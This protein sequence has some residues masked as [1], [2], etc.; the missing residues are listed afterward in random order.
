M[1]AP[2][3][4]WENSQVEVT[5]QS[6]LWGQFE[7]ALLAGWGGVGKLPEIT[8]FLEVLL[9]RTLFLSHPLTSLPGSTSNTSCV[10]ES[11][12]WGWFWATDPSGCTTKAHEAGE[13]PGWAP[14]HKLEGFPLGS[15]N[16]AGAWGEELEAMCPALRGHRRW[17][18][19]LPS[20]DP[21]TD[22][23]CGDPSIPTSE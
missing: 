23:L 3:P 14:S 19:Q 9:F 18:P 17:L 22:A 11:S 15:E 20:P 8:V 5:L 21:P 13:G 6:P 10:P 12:P 7:A 16:V 1:K 4:S 2:D